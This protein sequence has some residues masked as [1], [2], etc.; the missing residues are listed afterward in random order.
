MNMPYYAPDTCM[1]NAGFILY[2]TILDL[3]NAGCI[4][5]GTI[6]LFS[7]MLVLSYVVLFTS[8]V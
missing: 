6:H 1:S 3:P 7:V 4:M 5:Y 2:G 8:S